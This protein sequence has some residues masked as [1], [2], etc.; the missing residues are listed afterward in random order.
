MMIRVFVALL[1]GAFFSCALPADDLI[2]DFLNPP[3]AARPGVYWYFMDGNL[4]GEEMVK[5]LESMAEVGLGNLVFLEVNVGVPQGPVKFMSEQW[6]DLYAN[7]VHAAERLGIDIT[8]GAG[9]GWTGSGGPWVPVEESMQHLVFSTVDTQGPGTFNDFLPVPEQRSTQ[10]HQMKD[11]FYEDV[12]VYAFP[13]CELVIDR[14]NEKAL[15]ERDPYSSY[16]DMRG[17]K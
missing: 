14:I 17:T 1:A 15:Y 11:P 2:Q 3:D 9:P 12:A 7:A 8:L 16:Y 4:N 10:W 6:Q 13:K 5:D